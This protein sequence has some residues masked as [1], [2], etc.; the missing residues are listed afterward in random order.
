VRRERAGQLAPQIEWLTNRFAWY[1]TPRLFECLSL[2]FRQ[3]EHGAFV[4]HHYRYSQTM[5]TFIVE[6][7]DATWRRAE[8]RP[9]G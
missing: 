6:C 1:G 7:D 9:N 4:A 2:T 5:S 3:S 8:A